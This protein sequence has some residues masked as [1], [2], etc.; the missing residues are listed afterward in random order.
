MDII[1]CSFLFCK[2]CFPLCLQDRSADFSQAHFR[3][4]ARCNT[5]GIDSVAGIEIIDSYKI[6]R[7]DVGIRL[8]GQPR[9]E[10]ICNT[11]L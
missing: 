1:F 4:I 11:A 2:K 9:Q 3:N 10:H 7:C 8:D 6:L 5:Q